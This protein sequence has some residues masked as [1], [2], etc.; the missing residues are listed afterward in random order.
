M[1][2]SNQNPAQVAATINTPGQGAKPAVIRLL[3]APLASNYGSGQNSVSDAAQKSV[4]ESANARSQGLD[5]YT[6]AENKDFDADLADKTKQQAEAAKNARLLN[7][8]KNFAEAV[9]NKDSLLLN[10]LDQ[11]IPKDIKEAIKQQSGNDPEAV[12]EKA[13]NNPVKVAGI[14]K[15]IFSP[16]LSDKMKEAEEKGD[17]AEQNRLAEITANVKPVFDIIDKEE[18]GEAQHMSL[19]GHV[20]ELSEK[21]MLTPQIASLVESF[22]NSYQ[23]LAEGENRISGVLSKINKNILSVANVGPK[24][25]KQLRNIVAKLTGAAMADYFQNGKIFSYNDDQ[26]ATNSVPYESQ[27]N[28]PVRRLLPDAIATAMRR[29]YV[30]TL[31]EEQPFASLV[32]R[33][34]DDRWTPN[35]STV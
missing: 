20:A 12:F 18:L 10:L 15:D 25:D 11:A 35:N 33:D 24:G 13:Q 32:M 19:L 29:I 5:A 3:Q 31:T 9:F 30:G 17:T 26:V 16:F 7:N 6:P 34:T 28:I 1:A 23:K 27:Y 22:E 4:Y 14:L 2:L 21:G 8:G